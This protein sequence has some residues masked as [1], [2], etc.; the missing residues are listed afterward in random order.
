MEAQQQDQRGSSVKPAHK[1]IKR[2]QLGSVR[3]GA[4]ELA[5][6]RVAESGT[7]LQR[8]AV[9][10][11]PGETVSGTPNPAEA[12]RESRFAHDFSR[13]SVHTAESRKAAQ[14]KPLRR[15]A[16]DAYE[17]ETG[18]VPKSAL[19]QP[20]AGHFRA[21]T[22][23]KAVRPKGPLQP[24]LRHGVERERVSAL[25]PAQSMWSG[26][27]LREAADGGEAAWRGHRATGIGSSPSSPWAAAAAT[28]STAVPQPVS[29]AAS[30]ELAAAWGGKTVGEAVAKPQPAELDF[31]QNL[32]RYDKKRVGGAGIVWSTAQAPSF[33]FNTKQRSPP[34]APGK[35]SAPSQ[36]P[37]WEA[38]PTLTARAKQGTVEA[39]YVRPGK[40]PTKETREG[41]PVFLNFSSAISRLIRDGE[42]EHCRDFERAYRIS[43]READTVLRRHIVG[44]VFGPRSTKDAVE[45]SVLQRLQS[46]LVH[47][48]LGS[49]KTGWM[50]KYKDLWQAS[51]ARDTKGWHTF[52]PWSKGELDWVGKF[53]VNVV[54]KSPTTRIN[55]VGPGQ[56]IRYSRP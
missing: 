21:S 32:V 6:D 27:P 33:E 13:V 5:E 37:Q 26:N 7:L 1:P 29:W 20:S 19:S 51:Q 35:A 55:K 9:R 47:R 53:W 23:V 45:Q 50:G 16:P 41:W 10:R 12:F 54:Q 11:I 39:Y 14:T 46:K 30:Q 31:I 42:A 52:D 49:D 15:P 34:K 44:R 4:A 18:G 3:H 40:Y 25:G 24:G 22:D 17:R 2:R 38:R 48:Q 36:T 56:L 8:A 28:L 43:L